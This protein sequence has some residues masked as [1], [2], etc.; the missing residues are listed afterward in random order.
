MKIHYVDA[1]NTGVSVLQELQPSVLDR[2]FLF[3]NNE[4]H[5]G[6]CANSLVT[7]I[8]GYPSG[9]NQADFQIIAHLA[10]VLSHLSKAERKALEFVLCTRDQHLWTAFKHQ[11]WQA[12]VQC[13]APY[14]AIEPEPVASMPAVAVP[15][16]T[17]AATP[18]LGNQSAELQL[19]N[20]ILKLLKSPKTCTELQKETAASQSAFTVAFNGL[21][22]SGSIQR[23]D[24]SKKHW[25]RAG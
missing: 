10:G 13:R 4:S 23:Q 1:E 7:C 6:A 9:P 22:K 14:I 11:C 3:S 12:G 24:G 15:A 8:S 18:A 16:A 21:I 20:R 25:L 19:Q 17:A 2:V 5:L